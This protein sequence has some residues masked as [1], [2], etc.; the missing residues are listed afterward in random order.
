MTSIMKKRDIQGYSGKG[1]RWAAVMAEST[2]LLAGVFLTIVSF[3]LLN[4]FVEKL[5]KNEYARATQAA[6]TNAVATFQNIERSLDMTASALSFS[7]NETRREAFKK[8]RSSLSG[9]DRLEQALV[10]YPKDDGKWEY[11]NLLPLVQGAPYKI[12]IDQSLLD[13]IVHKNYFA[14]DGVKIAEKSGDKTPYAEPVVFARQDTA[15]TPYVLIRPVQKDNAS[16]GLIVALG[17]AST[18]FDQVWLDSNRD[19]SELSVRDVDTDSYLFR[20]NQADETASDRPG[21]V[22]EFA[23]AGHNFEIG[24]SYVK[25]E[26]T[27]FLL[28]VPYFLVL[29]GF[30]LTTAGT[31]YIHG[32]QRQSLRLTEINNALEQ[33]NK[34]LER[35]AAKREQLNSVLRKS[36]EE[37]RSVIDSVSDIIFE[38]DTSGKIL[39]LN[40]TWHK[41]TGFEPEQSRGTDLFIMLHPQE[42]EKQRKDFLALV[43][44]QKQPYRSFTRLRTSDGSFRAIELSISMIRQ[45]ESKTLRVVGTLTD[46]EERRRAERALGEAEKKYRAIVEN[47]AGGIFQ[48][49]PEGVYL[50][51]NPALARILGY[52]DSEELLRSVKNANE[53]IY[54][55]AR[56]RQFFLK[57]LDGAGIINN[58][59]TQAV[60]KD[61][62]RIWVNENVRVV[63]DEQGGVL[64]YEGSL[65]DITQR[66]E[67][68]MGL[69]EATIH[70]DLANRAK[71]EFLANMSHELRTPLNSII[72]FSEIIKNETFGALGQNA[73]KEYAND[74][75][76]SG[77]K[78]LNI[79]NEILDIAKIEAG[80]RHLNEQVV[81][82][83]ALMEASVKLLDGKARANNITVSNMLRDVPRIVGEELAVKQVFVNILSNAIKFTPSGGRVTVTNE[84]DSDGSLN[85]SITDTGVGLDESEIEK[86]LSPFGQIENTFNR[87]NAGTG[88]GLTLSDALMKLHDGR[89]ELFSQ[90]GIGTTVTII[91]PADRVSKGKAET[92]QSW[93]R[94]EKTP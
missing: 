49:T 32:T 17:R 1:W 50:S 65:E 71:S 38:T 62:S 21:Y 56:E 8:I 34:E 23:F 19:V 70:S 12:R 37:N 84:I 74:I 7:S 94:G 72:G 52:R 24:A 31:L 75:H 5:V 90:K 80:E 91:F 85:L 22:Y 44:G 78:L 26:K 43:K 46:V 64:F 83:Y 9:F 39:F 61:G 35:E 89:L 14:L 87:V 81:D 45:D 69:R 3:S 41:I 10:L 93:K 2:F 63:R 36:E 6:A 79:I 67:A 59:E 76:E 82:V 77:R 57:E 30:I 11:Y 18:V 25:S 20:Q 58:Y 28:A 86:A 13:D 33:K 42:Q 15:A 60:R 48:L 4:M 55:N 88:L 66:K 92:A 40:A 16:A 53:S 29:F 73:Y 47:A 51:A 54:F 27:Y 68:E